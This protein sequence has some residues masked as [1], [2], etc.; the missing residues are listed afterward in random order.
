MAVQSLAEHLV[1]VAQTVTKILR[2]MFIG[3]LSAAILD[4]SAKPEVDYF[5]CVFSDG[6]KLR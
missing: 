3:T 1:K 2:F 5:F 6:L 4:F